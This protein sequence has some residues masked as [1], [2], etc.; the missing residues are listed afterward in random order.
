MKIEA[1]EVEIN[2]VVSVPKGKEV[3]MAEPVDGMEYVLIRAYSAGVHA[4]YLKARKGDEVT[5]VQSRRIWYWDGAASISQIAMEGVNKP[6]NCKFSVP[7]NEITV[8]G[9]IEV[10][11]CTATAMDNIKGVVEWKK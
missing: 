2:G 6:K 8:L 1:N 10:L 11:P 9:V 3:K 7:V 5:L 4:G